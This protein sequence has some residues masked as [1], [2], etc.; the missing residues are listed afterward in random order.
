[1]T[2]LHLVAGDQMAG[3]HVAHRLI[4]VCP[5][6]SKLSRQRD[7]LNPALAGKAWPKQRPPIAGGG[8][9]LRSA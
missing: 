3:V 5:D 9:R 8:A 4:E 7:D 2:S 1:V 6:R